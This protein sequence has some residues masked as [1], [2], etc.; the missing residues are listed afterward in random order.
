MSKKNDLKIEFIPPSSGVTEQYMHQEIPAEYTFY[1][2]SFQFLPP[3]KDKVFLWKKHHKKLN[4]ELL[5]S[6]DLEHIVKSGDISTVMYF[7]QQIVESNIFSMEEEDIGSKG[8]TNAFRILQLGADYLLQLRE[9]NF[10]PFCSSFTEEGDMQIQ[11]MNEEFLNSVAQQLN[12]MAMLQQQLRIQERRLANEIRELKKIKKEK[13]DSIIELKRERIRNH[14]H[15][16]NKHHHKKMR[17]AQKEMEEEEGIVHFNS[18]DNVRIVN[19]VY[20]L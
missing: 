16:R 3:P 12:D 15:R 6:L 13:M 11:Y 19:V 9:R 20:D 1:P 5:A 18:T 14:H 10:L 4:K 2:A 17:K 7:F 8:F